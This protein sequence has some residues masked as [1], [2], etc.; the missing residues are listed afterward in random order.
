MCSSRMTN[1]Y[2]A[3][4]M[5]VLLLENVDALHARK[6]TPIIHGHRQSY[7][8]IPIIPQQ[9]TLKIRSPCFFYNQSIKT[10]TCIFFFK[11]IYKS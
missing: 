5:I 1:S 2:R 10:E 7:T 4:V 8:S 11:T 9:Q 6:N 3:W